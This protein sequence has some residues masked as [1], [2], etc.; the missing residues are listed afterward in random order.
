MLAGQ[1]DKSVGTA[2]TDDDFV[3]QFKES[4]C[5]SQTNARSASG[6][7]NG[8]SG[9]FHLVTFKLT[10][11]FSS[12]F[13]LSS[14]SP[15]SGKGASLSEKLI[16]RVANQGYNVVMKM[17][18]RLFLDLDGVLADFDTGVVRA[19]G[20]LP[21][22]LG[23]QVMWPLLAR[24]PG[25]YD[26]L[27]WTVDGA[28]L[29][30]FSKPWKPTILTGLPRG[31]WAERQKRSWCARELGAGVEVVCCLSREKAKV[32]A[33]VLEEGQRMVLV[34]DRLKLKAPWEDAGGEFVLHISA[35]SS[36]EALRN[37]GI[38]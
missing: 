27:P 38:T 3:A 19:T 17:S 22:Q 26:T 5:H 13:L 4:K 1:F 7:D 16:E 8:V 34:D 25:F 18:Y 36:I 28:V 20:K 21:A 14:G 23:D 29:W 37:L 33:S 31:N 9:K 32:A 15:S 11:F 6:N 30:E 12:I 24:T 2:A 10:V 35:A